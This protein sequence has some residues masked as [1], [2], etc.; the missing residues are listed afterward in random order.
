M[1]NKN[2]FIDILE[3]IYI[4]QAI[5]DN[6]RFNIKDLSLSYGGKIYLKIKDILEKNNINIIYILKEIPEDVNLEMLYL[7][8]NYAKNQ[9]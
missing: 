8:E 1:Q 4:I 2:F 3:W 5:S 9:N 6:I 7:Y